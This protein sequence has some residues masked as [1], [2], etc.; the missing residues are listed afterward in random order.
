MFDNWIIP[1]GAVLKYNEMNRPLV[2]VELAFVLREGLSGPGVNVADVIRCTD[3][4]VP[5][6]EI[7]D[8]RQSDRG[9]KGLIDSISDAAACG[10]VV[11][12]GNPRRLTDIDVRRIGASLAING[13]IEESGVASAVMSNPL[14]AVAWLINKL[15]EFGVA[16]E[17]GHVILSGSFIKAIPFGPGAT[18]AAQFDVLG[19]VTFSV[20]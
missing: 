4:V 11:L 6:I 12:G 3:F 9:P 16:P 7:V 1:E 19:E 17:A 20:E 18:V 14:N 5:A 13:V 2:E 10:L 15:S 8:T